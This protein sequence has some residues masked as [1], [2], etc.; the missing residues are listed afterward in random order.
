MIPMFGKGLQWY[1][2]VNVLD[3]SAG[4]CPAIFVLLRVKEF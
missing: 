3:F 2:A 1:Y 4:I